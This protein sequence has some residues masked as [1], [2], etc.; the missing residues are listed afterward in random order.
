[1]SPSE[2]DR[3][4]DDLRVLTEAQAADVLGISVW[5][6]QRMRKRGEGPPI[7]HI[8]PRRIGYTVGNLRRHLQS[9]ERA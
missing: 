7:T 9:R 5:T 8:S 1:M 4:V 3:A 2:R 6:L